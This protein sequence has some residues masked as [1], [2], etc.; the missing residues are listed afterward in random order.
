SPSPFDAVT[1]Q[2]NHTALLNNVRAG[3][4]LDGN[5]VLSEDQNYFNL[6]GNSGAVLGG[7]PDLVIMRDDATGT[8]YDIKTGQPRA[9]DN[10]Q[11]MIYMYALPYVNQFRGVEFDG[12]LVYKE[13]SEVEIPFEAIDD[14]FKSHLFGLIRRISDSEPARKV[15]SALEC[16]MCDITLADCPEMIEGD[17]RDAIAEGAEF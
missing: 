8:I 3:L 12:R 4:E 9:S 7:K 17:P 1:W 6:R 5:R 16:G 15:P 14:S 13:G 10:A 11:V 2:M